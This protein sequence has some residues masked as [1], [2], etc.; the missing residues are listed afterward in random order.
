MLKV[1]QE[2]LQDDPDA[3]P[4]DITSRLRLRARLKT[5]FANEVTKA[6]KAQV[7]DTTL[8][9]IWAMMEWDDGLKRRAE[10]RK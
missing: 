10:K 4:N 8:D 5:E 9:E 7:P 2:L 1:T 3:D 6:I